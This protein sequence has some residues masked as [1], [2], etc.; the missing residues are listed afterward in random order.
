ME[1]GVSPL[2]CGFVLC[3]GLP[4]VAALSPSVS[5]SAGSADSPTVRTALSIPPPRWPHELEH[6][7]QS[8]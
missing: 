7:K 8:S 1:S 3:S 4:P 6:L 2:N 5:V